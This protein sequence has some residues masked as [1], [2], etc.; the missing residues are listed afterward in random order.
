MGRAKGAVVDRREIEF[1]QEEGGGELDEEEN[2]IASEHSGEQKDNVLVK[3][4]LVDVIEEQKK[5]LEEF[6]K[7]QV[8]M[9]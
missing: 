3:E 9:L 8:E 6:V 4:Y 7:K 5:K 1:E 2:E